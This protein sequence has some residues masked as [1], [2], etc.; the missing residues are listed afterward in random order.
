[1]ADRIRVLHVLDTLDESAAGGERA[2]LYLA[3]HLPADRFEVLLCTTRRSGGE[4]LDQ[5][6]AAG[7]RHFDLRRRGRADLAGYGALL[8]LIR[9]VRPD[10][11]HTHMYGS[12]ASGMVF[13]AMAR[14]PVRVAHEQTWSYE[15]APLRRFI[16]GQVIGRLAD[17]FVAVSSADAE[18]M[19]RIEHVPAHKLRM[20]PNAWSARAEQV[21][22]DLRVELGIGPEVPLAASVM[23]MRPQKRLDVMVDAF[24]V[25]L[26][27]LPDAQLLMVGDG[28]ERARVI[29]HIERL[30]LQHA[31]RVLGYREDVGSVW[32]AADVLFL[33]SDF[34]GTPLSM[35]EG[36]AA[37]TPVVSTEIGG[38]PDITNDDCAVL[39][40]RRDPHALGTALATV[41]G[42]PERRRRMGEAA[43][44]TAASFTAEAHARKFAELYESLLAKAR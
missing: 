37:G 25:T 16:D 12:N 13:G 24:A 15:G 36:M 42:D 20:I 34:E 7:V 26:Q 39:V 1:M 43:R 18:R 40:P 19:E 44:T 11:L 28:P 6:R 8:R 23:V 41:L 33:S 32:E 27:H 3:T 9:Q 14:V 17:V 30:G 21:G 38:V 22:A 4:P 31:I 10:V 5:L 29:A 2:A 35:L